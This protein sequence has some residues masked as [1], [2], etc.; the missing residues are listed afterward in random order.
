[1][2][3]G[4]SVSGYYLAEVKFEGVTESG[5]GESLRIFPQYHWKT[6]QCA[7]N[8]CR[9]ILSSPENNQELP[10]FFFFTPSFICWC[11]LYFLYFIFVL[12]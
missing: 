8:I 1:M 10:F 4:V 11:T 9:R 12:L 5:G 6:L 7:K 3:C 2:S